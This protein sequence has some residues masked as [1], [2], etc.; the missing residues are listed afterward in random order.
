MGVMREHVVRDDASMTQSP[1]PALTRVD[2]L[3][4]SYRRL[5][6]VFHDVLSEQRSTPCSTGSPTRS[7]T[8]CPSTPS[9]STRR[10]RPPLPH[11]ADGPRQVGGGDHERP[12]L[13]GRGHHRLGRR[14]SPAA[15]RQPGSPRP[16]RPGRSGHAS[17]RARG[18]HHHPSRRAR[19]D[20]GRAQHLPARGRRA[21]SPRRSSSSRSASATRPRSRSTTRRSARRSSSRRRPTPSPASTTTAT[22]TNASARS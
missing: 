21:F 8:S 19:R 2:T 3:V 5:A 22:S 18:A 9:R 13:F 4:D 1:R 11:S 12:P 14:A 16:A 17:G 15:A 7:A 20:Q 10:T 6:D